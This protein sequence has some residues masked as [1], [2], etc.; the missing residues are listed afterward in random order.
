ML[1]LFVDYLNVFFLYYM[2]IY[3]I[4]FFISTIFAILNLNEDKRNKMYLNELSLK[5][6]DN[7]VPVSILVQRI[8]RKK[9]FAIVLNRYRM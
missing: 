4:V 1:R 9:Q 5:S 6:T 3:A 2:F 8:M 7:Y